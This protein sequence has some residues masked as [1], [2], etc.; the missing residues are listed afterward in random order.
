MVNSFAG[1]LA[2]ALIAGGGSSGH[3][4]GTTQAAVSEGTLTVRD[5]ENQKQDVAGLSRDAEHANG[6]ISPIFDK[7]KEQRRL[8]EV[9]LIAQIG[10]Q[11]ADIARTQGEING[12]NAG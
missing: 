9:Q 2:N 5:T 12:L 1:N 6:S 8:Q 11:A 3:A 10:N 7:E 4:E